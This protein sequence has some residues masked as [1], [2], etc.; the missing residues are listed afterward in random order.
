MTDLH[1]WEAYDAAVAAGDA[2]A[3][4]E[5][6]GQIVWLHRGFFVT[7]ANQTRMPQWN[8]AAV[9]DY[10]TEL[11]MV[12]LDKVG[13]YRRDMIHS[14]G[15]TAKF[16]TYVKPYLRL[17]RYRLEGDRLPVRVGHETIRLS[18]AARLYQSQN[19]DADHDDIAAHL[20]AKF[21]KRIGAGRIARLLSLPAADDERRFSADDDD[22][23]PGVERSLL[24]GVI[25]DPAELVADHL[26]QVATVARVREALGQLELGEVGK[27]VLVERLMSEEPVRVS[28][29]AVRLGV[30]DM[31]VVETEQVLRAQL[32]DLLR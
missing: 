17:V 14:S 10:L 15:N 19:W 2:D 18:F 21:G 25:N 6:A 9:E 5:L 24:A 23:R 28:D 8:S 31:E 20:S 12:A 29:I 22:T 7:Y 3:A 4:A 32:R 1:L 13:T 11:L 30:T 16:V 27:A 26:E